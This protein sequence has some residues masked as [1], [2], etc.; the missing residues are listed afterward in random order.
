MCVCVCAQAAAALC[1]GVGSFSDPPDLPGLAHFLEHSESSRMKLESWNTLIYRYMT[2]S[3]T[4]LNYTM[5]KLHLDCKQRLECLNTAWMSECRMI[6]QDVCLS[7]VCYHCFWASD[8]WL[9]SARHAKKSFCSSCCKE[10]E[11]WVDGFSSI[12]KVLIISFR[13]L[14]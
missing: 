4:F 5:S 6:I 7:S 12:N 8:T 9:F 3:H 1:I 14:V 13:L 10:Q 11:G 2:E